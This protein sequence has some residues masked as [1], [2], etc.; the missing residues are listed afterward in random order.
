[1]DAEGILELAIL[2]I[3]LREFTP[4]ILSSS[5]LFFLLLQ[6]LLIC[7]PFLLLGL[8]F[9][10]FFVLFFLLSQFLGGQLSRVDFTFI[11]FEGEE[12]KGV[13]E[14]RRVRLIGGF[15]VVWECI[16]AVYGEGELLVSIGVVKMFHIYKWT[17]TS[18][19]LKL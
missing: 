3:L 1:M 10:P 15:P 13:G 2:L 6:P 9:A 8:L 19:Y 11:D 4:L 14:Q 7:I 12:P 5:F 18:L 16:D 17:S